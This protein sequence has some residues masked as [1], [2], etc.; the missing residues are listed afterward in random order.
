MNH[1]ILTDG[2]KGSWD[3]E[4]DLEVLVA[5]RQEEQRS[6]AR[7]LGSTGDVGFCG[8]VDGELDVTLDRRG[9]GQFNS[10]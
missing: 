9:Q 7:A 3:P 10:Q 1:L 2:A 6:A 8:W 5:L 4:Q